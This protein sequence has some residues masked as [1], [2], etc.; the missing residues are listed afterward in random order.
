MDNPEA[1]AE[2]YKG[3]WIDLYEERGCHFFF[4]HKGQ[5]EV[6]TGLAEG[7][8]TMN[9]CLCNQTSKTLL[10]QL[11][12]SSCVSESLLWK[13]GTE[14]GSSIH[15]FVHWRVIEYQAPWQGLS[16]WPSAAVPALKGLAL[17]REQ[18]AID[19]QMKSSTHCDKCFG[20]VGSWSPKR[21]RKPSL[22]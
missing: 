13:Q 17:M 15:V 22:C 2:S 19:E 21:I 1:D 18:W 7:E 3:N 10:E 6:G 4:Q 14:W 8:N 9:T 20:T 5:W 12:I 16:S 11:A